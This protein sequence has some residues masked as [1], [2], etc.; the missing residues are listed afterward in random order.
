MNDT[1]TQH[2][3]THPLD[4]VFVEVSALY[5]ATH[6]YYSGVINPRKHA[7]RKVICDLNEAQG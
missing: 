6:E 2:D 4:W 7:L 5:C 3:G 1:T